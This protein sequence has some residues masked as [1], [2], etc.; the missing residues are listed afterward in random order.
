MPDVYI[1]EAKQFWIGVFVEQ[2]T[3]I[4]QSRK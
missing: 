1:E 4:Q 3:V 2:L